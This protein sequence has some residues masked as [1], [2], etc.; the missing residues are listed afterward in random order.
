MSRRRRPPTGYVAEDVGVRGRGRPGRTEV[1]EAFGA[2]VAS[3]ILVF[4]LHSPPHVPSSSSSLAYRQP[5]RRAQEDVERAHTAYIYG[6][7]VSST[8]QARHSSS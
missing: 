3:V 2:Y 1:I 4:A 6:S 7:I 8:T 5:V